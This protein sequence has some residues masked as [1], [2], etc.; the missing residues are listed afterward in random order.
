MTKQVSKQTLAVQALSDREQYLQV[1][2]KWT[3]A[4]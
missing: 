1:V 3:T 4:S 2:Y